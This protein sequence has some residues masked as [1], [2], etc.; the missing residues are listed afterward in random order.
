MCNGSYGPTADGRQKPEVWAPGCGSTSAGETHC[1]LHTGGGTSYAAP[2]VAGMGLLVR[3]YFLEGFY[4]SGAATPEDAVIPSGALLKAVLFNSGVDMDGFPDYFG[5]YE[6][7]GR[8]LMDDALYFTGDARALAVEDVRNVAGLST[9]EA[10]TYQ[11]TVNSSDEPLKITVVWTDVPATLGASFTPVNNLDLVVTDPG[12]VTYLGNVFGGLESAPGGTPDALNNGEQVHRHTPVPGLWQIDIAG[13]EVNQD[14]QGY[15]LVVTGDVSQGVNCLKG[16]VN[17]DG[18]INGNDISP[19]VSV[20]L[21]GG[22]ALEECAA[23]MD[24]TGGPEGGDVDD[25]IA[26]LL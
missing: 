13:T 10:D 16:D 23:D 21:E 24:D 17:G 14:T 25:F 19:F 5:P 4:P 26:A 18:L 1:G 22:T 6:G 20:I 7:W 2:A 9:G 8:I 3:Q 12:G 11:V 15:A